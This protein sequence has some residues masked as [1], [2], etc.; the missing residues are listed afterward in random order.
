MGGLEGRRHRRRVGNPL[1][2]WRLLRAPRREA[3]ASGWVGLIANTVL[4]VLAIG[5]PIIAALTN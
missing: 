2:Y 4:A 1:R 3:V 5:M